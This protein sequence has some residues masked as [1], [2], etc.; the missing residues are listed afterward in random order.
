MKATHTD[1]KR[2]GCLR[3]EGAP[4]RRIFEIGKG[5][6][7]TTVI[8]AGPGSPEYEKTFRKGLPA[9]EGSPEQLAEA[10]A[11]EPQQASEEDTSED[12]S[13]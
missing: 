9:W 1:Y 7:D 11:A 8:C 13:K 12:T 5:W 4:S 6:H 2:P 3:I 10:A